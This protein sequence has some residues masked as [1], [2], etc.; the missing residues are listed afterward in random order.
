MLSNTMSLAPKL[1]KVHEFFQRNTV[2]VGFITETWLKDRIND[3]LVN[4]AGY[5][6]FRKDRTVRYFSHL[7]YT[8]F[9]AC[10]IITLFS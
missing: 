9:S 5:N 10:Q 8:P 1:V 4:I 6:I 7:R 2:D 3:S